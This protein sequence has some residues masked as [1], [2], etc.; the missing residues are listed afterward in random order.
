[1][2][3]VFNRWWSWSLERFSNLCCFET[4]FALFQGTQ[5][6]FTQ[7]LT[8]FL[9]I[10][11]TS[12]YCFI[13]KTWVVREWTFRSW[14]RLSMSDPYPNFWIMYFSPFQWSQNNSCHWMFSLVSFLRCGK[15]PHEGLLPAREVPGAGFLL[16][17]VQ[18]ARGNVNI[19]NCGEINRNLHRVWNN[20]RIFFFSGK[21]TFILLPNWR[22]DQKAWEMYFLGEM[23]TFS[24][25]SM[26][27]AV[28]LSSCHWFLPVALK[29]SCCHHVSICIVLK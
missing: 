6:W 16:C 2:L 26:N 12:S 13:K 10:S 11:L 17:L 4:L 27:S 19:Y 1:M 18:I 20:H 9:S 3:S 25:C 21:N 8:S 23:L 15:Q 14:R 28:K 7:E 24:S 5:A 22:H 29:L